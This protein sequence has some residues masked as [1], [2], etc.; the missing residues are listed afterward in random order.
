MLKVLIVAACFAF[1]PVAS[2]ATYRLVSIESA[3]CDGAACE[4]IGE[5]AEVVRV[6]R[7]VTR[8]RLLRRRES[9]ERLFFG[10]PIRMFRSVGCCR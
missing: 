9:R 10:R 1:S 7:T 4:S 8:A 3:E 5:E 2:A 6:T